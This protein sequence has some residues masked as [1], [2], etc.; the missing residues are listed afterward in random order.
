MPVVVAASEVGV[1]RAHSDV[2][3]SVEEAGSEGLQCDPL[4][5]WGSTLARIVMVWKLFGNAG[6]DVDVDAI[7]W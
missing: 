5:L 6:V 2:G 1:D 3:G 4:V 7:E